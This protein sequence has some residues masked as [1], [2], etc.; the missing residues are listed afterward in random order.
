MRIASIAGAIILLLLLHSY[1]F[2]QDSI[3]IFGKATALPDKFLRTVNDKAESLE[4]K[5]ISKTEKALRQLEKQELRLKR[6]LARKDSL[7]ANNI[8][9]D[10]EDRYKLLSNELKRKG[11]G[12]SRYKEYLPG[13]DSLKTSLNFLS[14]NADKLLP[15]QRQQIQNALQKVTSLD[16]KLQSAD[17][18]RKFLKDRRQ[19]LKTQLD[20]FGLLKEFQKYNKQA[21]Y[22]SQQIQEYKSILQDQSK[23]ERL[24]LKMIRKVPAFEK[25]F[26]EHSELASLF[27]TPSN[28][29]TFAGLQGLQTRVEIQQLIQ[30]R[31]S[32]GGPNAEQLV[33]QNIQQAQHALL[34]LKEK[35]NNLGGSNSEF[36]IPDFK[37]NTQRTK[38][39][40]KR[41]E[42]G[43]N[44]QNTRANS[45]LPVT[46]EIGVSIGYRMSDK[47]TIGIGSSYKMGFSGGID[48]LTLTHEGIGLRSYLDWQLKGKIFITGGYEQNYYSRFDDIHDLQNDAWQQSALI[49][50]TRKYKVGKKFKGEI[51]LLFDLLYKEYTPQG[52]LIKFR[53][54]YGL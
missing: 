31:L 19:L 39:F 25:F 17:A 37:P 34:R 16:S 27:P 18:I 8:F 44:F 26:Q 21:Y 36:D 52:Q 1:A 10:V 42:F 13:F 46:S 45:L 5:I 3:S 20:K 49:G 32:A 11:N 51:R 50:L 48:H 6:K 43:T 22:Y 40:L 12:I 23:A 33:Q 15:E 7:A 54:G 14:V 30:S 28:F 35:I 47:G 24:A 4:E 2:C 41:L 29:G 53:F 38:P 9:G